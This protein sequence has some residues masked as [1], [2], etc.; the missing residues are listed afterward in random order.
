MFDNFV[1]DQN[2]TRL[3][4]ILHTV[5]RDIG[6]VIG[7]VGVD[8]FLLLA[9]IDHHAYVFVEFTAFF[10][11]VVVEGFEEVVVHLRMR[12]FWLMT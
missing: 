2:V 6:N 3:G 9:L 10:G 4:C 1:V 8:A 7:Q 5:A 12:N 11:K